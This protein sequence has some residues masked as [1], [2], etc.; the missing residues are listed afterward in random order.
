MNLTERNGELTKARALKEQIAQ[1]E[2]RLDATD[3]EEGT[4]KDELQE[5]RREF[6]SLMKNGKRGPPRKLVLNDLIHDLH[7]KLHAL[8]REPSMIQNDLRRL[9]SDLD[10]FRARDWW[11][12][13]TWRDGQEKGMDS[14]VD[15]E[16]EAQCTMWLNELQVHL[17]TFPIGDSYGRNFITKCENVLASRRR[18]LVEGRARNAET[19][20]RT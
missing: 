7:D 15:V 1:A 16:D 10:G 13:K 19:D 2:A 6:D 20:G 3:D 17:D 5:A 9:G 12:L 8:A 18:N 14:P 4:L 11:W